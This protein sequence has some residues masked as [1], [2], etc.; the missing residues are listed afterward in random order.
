MDEREDSQEGSRDSPE[1]KSVR[2]IISSAREAPPEPHHSDSTDP[3]SHLA[4]PPIT[5]AASSSMRQ[6]QPFH[7]DNPRSSV[8]MSNT[9][10]AATQNFAPQR[11]FQSTTNLRGRK[12][13]RSPSTFAAYNP[14]LPTHRD[15]TLDRS[16]VKPWKDGLEFAKDMLNKFNWSLSNAREDRLLAG[17]HDIASALEQQRLGLGHFLEFLEAEVKKQERRLE[18]STTSKMALAGAAG[19]RGATRTLSPQGR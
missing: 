2:E 12:R 11:S 4:T 1:F 8:E 19:G 18:E 10:A 16:S 15:G 9:T 7:E 13:E 5:P 17:E 14:R 3:S 6:R